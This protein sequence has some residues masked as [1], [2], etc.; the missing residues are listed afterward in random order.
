[1]NTHY[2]N[3]VVTDIN[4][5]LFYLDAVGMGESN[6]V[7]GAFKLYHVKVKHRISGNTEADTDLSHKSLQHKGH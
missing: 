2:F 3:Q 4:R 5:I 1:M 6:K 7:L